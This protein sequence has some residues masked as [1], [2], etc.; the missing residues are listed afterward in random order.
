MGLSIENISVTYGKYSS[1]ALQNVSLQVKQGEF[2]GIIGS[3]GAGK[4]TLIR[5]INMLVRPTSGSIVWNETELTK[6]Q[7]RE[8]RKIRTNIGMIFQQFQLVPRL[9]VM[10]NVLLGTLG[11]RS[12]WKNGLGY[13]SKEEQELAL[14]SLEQV[15]LEPFA[16]QRV[17]H[18]SGG[19]QQRVAIARLILQNPQVILG[20]EPVAS[21]DPVISRSIMD[22]LQRIHKHSRLIT[23]MN[24]HNVE[25]AKQYTTRIIGL[26]HGKVVFDGNP[27]EVTPEIQRMIYQGFPKSPILPTTAYKKIPVLDS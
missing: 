22:I 23:I 7:E 10:T 20:D 3:S 2:V 11:S 13:F 8:L 9:N 14:Q 27:D 24:L 21:L 15:G 4:S 19:Q 6:L 5:C 12:F 25:L 1:P 17:E 18:L 16:R 26:S